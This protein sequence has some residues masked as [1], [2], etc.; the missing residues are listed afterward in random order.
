MGS[1]TYDKHSTDCSEDFGS[2]QIPPATGERYAA[3]TSHRYDAAHTSTAGN[4]RSCRV[5]VQPKGPGSVA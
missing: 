1:L 3:V 2:A 4:V 5:T